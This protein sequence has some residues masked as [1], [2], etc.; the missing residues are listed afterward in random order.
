RRLSIVICHIPLIDM[1]ELVKLNIYKE[2]GD[3]WAWVAP[4]PKRQQVVAAG[5][6]ETAKDAPTIDEGAQ[7]VLAPVQA[8]QPPLPPPAVGKTI[9]H[10]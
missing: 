10:R 3:Y 5:A 9:P 1:G 6:L 2:I 8:P 7:A 4:R